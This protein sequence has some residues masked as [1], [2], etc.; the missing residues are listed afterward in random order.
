VEQSA[1]LMLKDD[2]LGKDLSRTI[3]N[4]I[5][6]QT[7]MKELSRNISQLGKPDAAAEIASEAIRLMKIKKSIL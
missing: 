3:D 1:A 5:F 2:L 7:R 4:L 6:D